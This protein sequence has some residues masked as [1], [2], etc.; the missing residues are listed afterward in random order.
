MKH[1]LP[2]LM[3]SALQAGLITVHQSEHPNKRI[4]RRAW[5]FSDQMT[6]GGTRAAEEEMMNWRIDMQA[7]HGPLHFRSKERRAPL[8]HGYYYTIEA[9]TT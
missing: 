9:Y 7:M 4:G 5:F 8:E 2:A 1:S 3:R 6:V